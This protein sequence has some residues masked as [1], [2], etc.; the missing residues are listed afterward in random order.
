MVAPR[1]QLI[2]VFPAG[3]LLV[4]ALLAGCSSMATRRDFYDPIIADI[5]AER[6][7]SAV[8]KL[9][10]ANAKNKFGH[11]D[12][13]LYFID[14]GLAR[15]YAGEYQASNEILQQADLAVQELFTKSVSR[16]AASALLNDNVLEYA[17]EDYEDLYINLIKALNYI[18]LEQFDEAFVEI[19][20]VNEKLQLLEQKYADAARELNK[21]RESDKDAREVKLEYKPETVQFYTDAF[22]HYL[23]MRLY[24]AVGKFDDARIDYDR[25]VEAF[26][27][28]P[29]VYD[30]PMPE[31][32]YRAREGT[33]LSA[34][35]LT[36]LGPRKEAF[37]LRLRSDKDL[38]LVQVLY[39][40]TDGKEAV[41]QHLPL[42]LGV[43]YYFKFAIPRLETR[44]S[45]VGDVRVFADGEEL[46]RLALLEDV[47]LVGKETFEANKSLIYVRTIIRAV[48]K[49]LASHKLKKDAD[50]GGLGGWL[51][52][53]AIDAVTDLTENADL[54]S[55]QLLP[56]RVLVGDFE[57]EP[58]VYDL[59]CKVYDR[60]GRLLMT[61][62]YPQYR[63]LANGLNLIEA[64]CPK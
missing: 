26:D 62:E 50:T 41:Y 40:D 14:D 9:D 28:Q 7:D 51:K 59:V 33:I 35:A 13:L 36:G 54:R 45:I 23:S 42:N 48:A 31:L 18:A 11:K 22:A 37:N 32:R 46:G 8:V 5:R 24:A 61:E 19:R 2:R 25:I 39:T 64:I 15:H 58:G 6:Y 16:A 4:A 44:P 55:A 57:I 56:G 52:K 21:G 20:R 3:L 29:L 1:A 49:A 30:F 63:V 10:E 47:G 43:D 27:T 12:R 17:G 53:A 34:V 60:D 38:E